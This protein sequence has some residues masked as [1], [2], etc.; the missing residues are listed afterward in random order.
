MCFHASVSFAQ[1]RGGEEDI[2][3]GIYVLTFSNMKAADFINIKR[4]LWLEIKNVTFGDCDLE[5]RFAASF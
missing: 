5:V 2:L 1:R 4:L 3:R